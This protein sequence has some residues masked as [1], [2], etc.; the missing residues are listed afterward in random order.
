[1]DLNWKLPA[2]S[3]GVAF[4]LAFIS[5]TV[6]GVQFG[7]M[8]L[9]SLIAA[10][11]FGAL[12]IGV[13]MLIKHYLPELAGGDAEGSEESETEESVQRAENGGVDITLD[14]ENPHNVGASQLETG[15]EGTSPTSETAEEPGS[16]IAGDEMI[17]DVEEVEELENGDDEFSNAHSEDDDEDE[18]RAFQAPESGATIDVMGDEQDP[19]TVAKAVRTLLK[20]DEEG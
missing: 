15:N 4:I 8:L 12:G 5:A 14:E 16:E 7:A 17:E 2:V 19:E 13:D 20:K 18:G 9:R 10:V 3:A 6:G 11:I 1:M